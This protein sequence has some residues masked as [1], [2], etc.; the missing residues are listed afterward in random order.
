MVQALQV[1]GC[2][3]VYLDGGFISNSPSPKDFDGCWDAYGIDFKKLD[4]VLLNFDNDRA[5]Q[6]QKYGGEMFP[7]LTPEMGSGKTFLDFFQVERNTG[8]QKGIVLITK[9]TQVTP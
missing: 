9:T 2:R 4:P 7:S 5:A 8:A 1:A 6:K 3:A